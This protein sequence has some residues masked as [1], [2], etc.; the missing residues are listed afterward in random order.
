MGQLSFSRSQ[1]RVTYHSRFI[2]VAS[3]N[4]CPCGY[5]NHPK[6]ECRCSRYKITKYHQQISG[7]IMD[8]I[9]LIVDVPLVDLN[10]LSEGFQNTAAVS[11]AHIRQ[12]VI[13]ARML[14]KKRFSA[15][16]IH[17]NSEMK[18]KHIK[19]Y[20]RLAADV[21][22][23]LLQAASQFHM[24]ARSYF[25]VIKVSRTIADLDGSEEIHLNHAAEALQYRS[26]NK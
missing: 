24:S 8:R 18:N 11:S 14:Q 21:K 2:L 12:N 3:A 9:D 6:I 20:C 17:T 13:N 7:P 19:K 26:K 23:L 22:S 16:G 15:D 1:N 4:P 25:K 10:E 5:L